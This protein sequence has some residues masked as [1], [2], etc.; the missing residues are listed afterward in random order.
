M[1]QHS[2]AK[3]TKEVRPY[4]CN[5]LGC[6]APGTKWIMFGST[7][8]GFSY[9]AQHAANILANKASFLARDEPKEVHL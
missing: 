8:P 2:H 3:T 7:E 4:P 6:E 9:C 1:T 5:R